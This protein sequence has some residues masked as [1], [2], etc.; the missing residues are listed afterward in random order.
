MKTILA[1]FVIV[2]SML[3]VA[4]ADDPPDFTEIVKQIGQKLGGEDLYVRGEAAKMLET[5]AN[6]ASRPGADA[7]RASLCQAMVKAL[8]PDT[9]KWGRV[10][11]LRQ[12]EKNGRAEVV[13]TLA[14]LSLDPDE[15]IRQHAVMSLAANPS[16]EAAAKLRDMLAGSDDSYARVAIINA[17]GYRRD[18]KAVV[19]LA[20]W[21]DDSDE[22]VSNAAVAALGAIGNGDALAALDKK[23]A[24]TPAGVDAYLRC[25]DALAKDN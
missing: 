25:L 9:P 17:I 19:N 7:E 8:G 11:L 5:L 21:M 10:W 1:V 12:L 18:A 24:P 2:V 23:V 15:L 3:A 13:E 4:R 20:K 6:H 22:R 14:G 16:D